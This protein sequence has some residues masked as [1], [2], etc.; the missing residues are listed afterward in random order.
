MKNRMACGNC[1]GKVSIPPEFAKARI[2]CGACGYYADVPE[3]LRHRADTAEAAPVVRATPPAQATPTAAAPAVK[4]TVRQRADPNDTRAEFAPTAGTGPAYH[5][6]NQ[7]EDDP[8]GYGVEGDGLKKCPDCQGE[9]PVEATFC[10]HC[11]GHLDI[12]GEARSRKKRR[13]TAIDREFGEG[14]PLKLRLILFGLCQAFNAFFIFTTI[15]LTSFEVDLMAIVTGGFAGL[16]SLVL[17]AFVLGSYDTLQVRRTE[18]GKAT[19]VRARRLLFLPI[20]P[21]KVEWKQCVGVGKLATS[22][23]TIFAWLVCA[24]LLVAGGILPGILFWW[25][26]LRSDNVVVV[27][28]NVYGGV[29]EK[30]FTTKDEAQGETVA[31]VVAEATRL[32]LNR[33]V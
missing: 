25:F 32:K 21:A 30:I 23:G 22:S 11:G 14:F 3:E 10:V 19:L 20:T 4:P 2:R 16:I 13:F 6:G 24:Y 27:L 33:V 18:R 8:T 12:T 17:Q 1:G 5:E 31:G 26:E 28:T 9:L 7:D 15:Q 29:E